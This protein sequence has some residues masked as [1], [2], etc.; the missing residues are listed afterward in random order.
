MIKY[1]K[2]IISILLVLIFLTPITVMLIDSQFHHHD[3]FICTAKTEHHFHTYHDICPI[4]DFEF[5]LYSLNKIIFETQK[6]IYD[7]N[8]FTNYVSN[9][10]YSNLKYSFALRAPPLSIHN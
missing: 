1:C 10:R 2:H 6:V 5:S 3:N 8:L 9:N 4:P 7:D